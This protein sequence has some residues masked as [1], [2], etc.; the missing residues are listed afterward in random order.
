MKEL[1]VP[2]FPRLH[3]WLGVW[4]LESTAAQTLYHAVQRIDWVAHLRADPPKLEPLAEL[5]EAKNGKTVA[6]VNI[7]G[8]LMKGRSSLGGT[9]TVQARRDVRNAAND[10]NVSA[11]LLNIDSPGGTVAG[12]DDLAADVRAAGRAKPVWAQADDLMASAAYWV[13]SQAERIYANAPTA[14]IGSI[15]TYL[16]VYDVSEAAARDGVKAL[17]FSTGPLKGAGAQG[18]AVTPEQQAYFKGIVEGVQAEFDRAVKSG[19]GLTA[20]QLAGVRTGGVWKAAEA[21]ARGLID[22]VQPVGKTIEQ[23]ARAAA[24]QGDPTSRRRAGVLPTL[25]LSVL[26]RLQRGEQQ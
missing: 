17:H 7:S 5:V 23:L 18:T 20:E 9:S 2:E 14:L 12:L 6:V 25:P 1:R 3:D 19:R 13:G 10:P 11:I 4:L 15:G 21:Q 24:G 16:T 22:G 8:T 26:P